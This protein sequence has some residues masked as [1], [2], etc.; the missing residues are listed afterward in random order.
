MLLQLLSLFLPL[1][2]EF[3]LHLLQLFL[4]FLMEFSLHSC[5]LV[6]VLA[7]LVVLAIVVCK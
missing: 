7:T 3:Q 2:F 1:F 4:R 6:V 5:N